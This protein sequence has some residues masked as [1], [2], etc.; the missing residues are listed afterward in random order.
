MNTA[1]TKFADLDIH[2]LFIVKDCLWTKITDTA[3]K[4]PKYGCCNFTDDPNDEYVQAVSFEDVQEL[5]LS[6][7][8]N[9]DAEND[10]IS[11]LDKQPPV[12]GHYD[13][14]SDKDGRCADAYYHK[15]GTWREEYL[16]GSL[17]LAVKYWKIPSLPPGARTK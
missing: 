16:D 11:I 4:C 17:I 8:K 10:W 3:A 14:W 6:A 7:Y 13:C 5:V 12:E 2:A 9:D 1:K 15:D